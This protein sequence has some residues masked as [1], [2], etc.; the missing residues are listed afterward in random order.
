[1]DKSWMNLPQDYEEYKRGLET[2][3]D[4]AFQNESHNEKILCPCINCKNYLMRTHEECRVH[5]I[6]HG[7]I[8]GYTRW[9]C[10]GEVSLTSFR[11]GGFGTNS[12]KGLQEER[13]V[14][15]N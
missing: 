7:F 6:C 10:H 15:M 14:D 3:L 8:K 12:Y 9:I 13:G 4:F 1:M 2:F 11:N 5:L